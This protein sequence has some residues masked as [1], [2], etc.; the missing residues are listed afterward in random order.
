[1]STHNPESASLGVVVVGAGYFGRLHAA[2]YAAMPGV[3]LKAVIDSNAERAASVAREFGT[4]AA[5]DYR[6]WLGH[7]EAVSIVTPCVTHYGIASDFLRAGSHVLLEKP[8]TA[9][10]DEADE[11][12]RLAGEGGRVLQVGHQE[13]IFVSGL[14]L[15]TRLQRPL[16]IHCRRFSPYSGRGTDCSVIM[17]VMIHDLDFVLNL[18]DAPVS[19]LALLASGHH[20][21][22]VQIDFADGSSARLEADRHSGRRQRATRLRDA[23]ATIEIDFLARRCLHSET[24]VIDNVPCPGI[25][26]HAHAAGFLDNDDLGHAIAAFVHSIR[27]GKPPTAP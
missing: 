15:E 20:E 13:R 27:N 3:V 18:I 12:I 6:P 17:D 26:G 8:M 11:L 2:K 1:M 10:L 14:D 7:A 25:N 5:T 4:E 23:S 22:A 24:G 19:D 16:N 21:A 9:T